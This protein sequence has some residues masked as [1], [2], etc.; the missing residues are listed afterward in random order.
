MDG[1]SARYAPG[2]GL[3]ALVGMVGGQRL[4]WKSAQAF[5]MLGNNSVDIFSPQDD[6]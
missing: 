5:E 4:G 3:V 6:L 2:I 1:T